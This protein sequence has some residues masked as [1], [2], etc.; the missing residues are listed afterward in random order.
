MVYLG[1]GFLRGGVPLCVLTAAVAGRGWC[2]E[3]ALIGSLARGGEREHVTSVAAALA[4]S[5]AIT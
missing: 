1:D 2:C 3:G 5:S 4:I